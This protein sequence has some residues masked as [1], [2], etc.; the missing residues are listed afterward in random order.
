MAMPNGAVQGRP[1]RLLVLACA[2][3]FLGFAPRAG[4]AQG[5]CPTE[6]Q[7]QTSGL[8]ADAS[9]LC[10]TAAG[11]TCTFELA[12]CVNQ[13]ADSCTPKDLKKRRIHAKGH[14]AGIGRLNL[15]ANGPSPAC[16]SFAGVKVRTEKHGSQPGT[17]RIHA[18]AGESRTDITLLC[19]PQSSPCPTTTTTTTQTPTT[20]TSTETA[21]TTTEAATTTTEAVTTT[22]E[23]ATTTT[24]LVTT[25]TEVST[26]TT[27]LQTCCGLS[28]QPSQLSFT[29]GVGSGNCGTLTTSTGTL[30]ENLACGGLYTG[31][32]SSGVPL[33]FTVPDMGSS[34]TGVS[35]CSGTSLTLANLT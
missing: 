7:E 14:C 6:F 22:T 13:A 30:L 19:Q 21:T 3:A 9:S 5:Q 32:G 33:P 29:T 34:L 31:G 16:G 24:E 11:K 18:K 26:T 1:G 25:T 23:A 20:T 17:C 35:S 10:A 27:T 15:K 28:P 4:H 12:L 2:T 8:V